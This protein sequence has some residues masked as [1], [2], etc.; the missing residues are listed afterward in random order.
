MT[1]IGME[2]LREGA[3]GEDL[4]VDAVATMKKIY[5]GREDPLGRSPQIYTVTKKH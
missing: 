1:K 5:N 4:K 2:C 3:G